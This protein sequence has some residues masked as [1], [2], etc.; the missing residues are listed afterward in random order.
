MLEADDRRTAQSQDNHGRRKAISGQRE[1]SEDGVQTGVR[2][3]EGS[4]FQ[5]GVERH[6]Q[7]HGHPR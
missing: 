4:A 7:E 2:I 1:V 3:D 5:D 6:H